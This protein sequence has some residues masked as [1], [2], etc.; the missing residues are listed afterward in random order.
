MVFV[1]LLVLS[2]ISTLLYLRTSIGVKYRLDAL[3]LVSGSASLMFLVDSLYSYVAGEGGF[4]AGLDTVILSIVLALVAV[5]VWLFLVL[6]DFSK[7]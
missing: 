7:R 2:L 6:T 1:A 3:A 4:E 5:S